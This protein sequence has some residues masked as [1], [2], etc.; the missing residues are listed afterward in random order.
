MDRLDEMIDVERQKLNVAK[1]FRAINPTFIPIHLTGGIGDVV[2]SIEAL[3]EL[4]KFYQ[5]VVFT[6]HLEVFEYFS[7]LPAMRGL[8]LISWHL[9]FNTI[10]RFR[11]SEQF[12]GFLMPQQKELFLKQQ[13]LFLK[14]PELYSLCCNHPRQDFLLCQHAQEKN[15]NRRNFVLYSLGLINADHD[16]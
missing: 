2:M 6:E 10:A 1:Y 3:E 5:F 14:E 13:E 16:S 4:H 11:F 9:E 15:L 12:S 8:P 7:D